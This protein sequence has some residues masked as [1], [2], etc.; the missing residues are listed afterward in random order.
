MIHQ[1]MHQ[2]QNQY[3]RNDKLITYNKEKYC[4]SVNQHFF[5]DTQFISTN[6]LV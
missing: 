2:I 1:C 6:S 3:L 4:Y 5:T